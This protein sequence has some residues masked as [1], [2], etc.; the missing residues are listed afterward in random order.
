MY[1]RNNGLGDWMDTLIDTGAKLAEANAK[2]AA[3]RKLANANAS[4]AVMAANGQTRNLTAPKSS[5]TL[6]YVGLGVG[7]VAVAGLV[8]WLI[9]R[10]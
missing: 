10:K 4:A 6:L 9:V 1:E 3:A 7:G 2:A 8:T 5:N